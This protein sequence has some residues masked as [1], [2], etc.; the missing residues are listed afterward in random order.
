MT[1][2]RRVPSTSYT[3]EARSKPPSHDAFNTMKV[4]PKEPER[5]ALESTGTRD[6]LRV[7][8]LPG[9][10]KIKV[11]PAAVNA[12]SPLHLALSVYEY[13]QHFAR[14]TNSKPTSLSWTHPQEDGGQPR[15]VF[16]EVVAPSWKPNA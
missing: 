1:K 8:S 5:S 14:V 11:Y 7:K 12:K 10:S 2:T 9:T 15:T 16:P 6:R 13:G 4:L 3:A